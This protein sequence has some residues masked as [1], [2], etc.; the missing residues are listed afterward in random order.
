MAL[1]ATAFCGC[2]AAAVYS[3]WRTELE[4]TLLYEMADIVLLSLG[5]CSGCH[6]LRFHRRHR[7][8]QT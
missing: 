5:H 3:K 2:S 6:A 8:G 1:S 7:A 4:C